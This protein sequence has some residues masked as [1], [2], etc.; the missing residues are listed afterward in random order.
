MSKYFPSLS[1]CVEYYY[2]FINYL[3]CYN[4]WCWVRI[5]YFFKS[6]MKLRRNWGLQNL[7][8]G[9]DIDQRPKS[10]NYI[11]VKKV[12]KGNLWRKAMTYYVYITGPKRMNNGYAYRAEQ[13]MSKVESHLDTKSENGKMWFCG[14]SFYD[15][16]CGWGY[17]DHP[18]FNL[19]I[20]CKRLQAKETTAS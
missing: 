19:I 1:C 3:L 14:G 6:I 5:I 17:S 13:G 12:K 10:N 16:R 20:Y 18:L 2:F 8:A 15:E 11:C 9:T 7:K 4:L